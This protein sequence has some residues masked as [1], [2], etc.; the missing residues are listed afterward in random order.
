MWDETSSLPHASTYTLSFPDHLTTTWVKFV[1]DAS[2]P[3]E[4]DPYTLVNTLDQGRMYLLPQTLTDAA[5]LE[6]NISL[7]KESGASYPLQAVLPPFELN[8]P[9]A[10]A[11]EAGKTVSYLVTL[12][13]TNL[14][15]L[16]IRALVDEWDGAGNSHDT[17][18]IF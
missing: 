3:G 13:I 2:G 18:T 10:V 8:L 16:D 7:Y 11:W 6:V 5:K 4:T 17:Q 12:D 14:L 15:V 1:G 9:T